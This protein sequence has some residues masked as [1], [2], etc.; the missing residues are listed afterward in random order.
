MANELSLHQNAWQEETDGRDHVKQTTDRQS[1]FPE[2]E[3]QILVSTSLTSGRSSTGRILA[4]GINAIIFLECAIRISSPGSDLHAVIGV[5]SDLHHRCN[6]KEGH[7][8]DSQSGQ[9]DVYIQLLVR[10]RVLRP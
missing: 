6:N 4:I 1:V 10:R 3:H 7:D 5:I 9:D 2:G 8:H